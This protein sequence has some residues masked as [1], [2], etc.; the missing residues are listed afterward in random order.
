MDNN[1]NITSVYLL[2]TENF[3]MKPESNG[4]EIVVISDELYLESNNVRNA[5]IS[6]SYIIFQLQHTTIVDEGII[7]EDKH[8]QDNIKSM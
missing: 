3:L 5:T 2:N 4:T 1:Y 6:L 8:W 7:F